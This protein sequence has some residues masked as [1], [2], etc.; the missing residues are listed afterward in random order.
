MLFLLSL[1][2]LWPTSAEYRAFWLKIDNPKTKSFRT[3]V[4]SLDPGQ[5]VRYHPLRAEETIVYLDTW[6]CKDRTGPLEP[7]CK[8]PRESE[9]KQY[10]QTEEAQLQK[11]REAASALD[12]P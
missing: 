10:L 3:E 8:S 4:S 6:M 2:F 9:I 1:F 11:L 12:T 5:Y 7:E